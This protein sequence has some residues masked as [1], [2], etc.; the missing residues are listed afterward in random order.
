MSE[1]FKLR[2]RIFKCVFNT[3][4]NLRRTARFVNRGGE[5]PANL[6]NVTQDRCLFRND[7]V[8]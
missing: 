1:L 4:R 7:F 2:A 6:T 8:D 5:Y 3:L